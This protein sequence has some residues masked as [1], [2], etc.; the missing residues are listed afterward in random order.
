M[1]SSKSVNLRQPGHEPQTWMFDHVA[2]D[3]TTQEEMFRGK[4]V[5]YIQLIT[6]WLDP[7]SITYHS[8]L[9]LESSWKPGVT[10]PGFVIEILLQWLGGLLLRTAWQATTAAFLPTARQV[11]EKH[12]QCRAPSLTLSRQDDL[13]WCSQSSAGSFELDIFRSRDRH[14]KDN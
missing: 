13:L 11:L 3:V 5:H 14:E 4:P 12:T 10:R 8:Q 9:W 2:G 6:K 1:T 7:K